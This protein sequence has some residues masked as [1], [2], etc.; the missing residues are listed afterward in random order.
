MLEAMLRKLLVAGLTLVTASASAQIPTTP[1]PSAPAAHGSASPAVPT[2]WVLMV[3]GE[4][5]GAPWMK[6][7]T[8][9]T[10]GGTV[11]GTGPWTCSYPA[12]AR[13]SDENFGFEEME[14]ACGIGE[15]EVQ[16][17]DGHRRGQEDGEG[18]AG[19]PSTVHRASGPKSWRANTPARR[20][21]P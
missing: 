20:V 17:E 12:T 19:H 15:A 10:L 3:T 18:A 21:T 5:D 13:G 1:A 9:E 8:P 14:I 6:T 2:Y 11:K 7:S 16:R 4:K